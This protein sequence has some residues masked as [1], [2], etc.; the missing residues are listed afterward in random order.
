MAACNSVI[1]RL[2]INGGVEVLDINGSLIDN[3]CTCNVVSCSANG[4]MVV[5]ECRDSFQSR[6][7]IYDC[8]SGHAQFVN[9]FSH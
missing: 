5:V 6:T 2:G 8:S 4:T 1:A 9:T 7:D 3:I